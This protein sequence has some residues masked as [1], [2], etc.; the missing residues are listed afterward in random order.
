M[1]NILIAHEDINIIAKIK[2]AIK[3]LD[4]LNAIYFSSSDEA[5]EYIEESFIDIAV[6]SLTMPIMN[7]DEIA[8][9]IYSI[10]P[11]A[12]FCFIYDENTFD[13]GIES[14]NKYLGSRIIDKSHFTPDSLSGA[15]SFLYE[16]YVAEDIYNEQLDSYRAKEKTYKTTMNEMS[17]MLNSR[18]SCYSRVTKVYSKSI[19]ELCLSFDETTRLKIENF[20]NCVFGQY[21]QDVL[22]E[23]VDINK[24]ILGLIES[25]NDKESQRHYQFIYDCPLP[26][27]D[28]AEN[29]VFSAHFLSHLF[30][31]FLEKFRMKLELK[32]GPKVYRLD[33]LV[34][35]RLGN[36]SD[37]ILSIL[38]NAASSSLKSICYKLEQVS[39]SGIVQIRIYYL[40]NLKIVQE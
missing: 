25:L 28:T 24:S 35:T 19:E 32:D 12:K 9:V 39:K 8:D 2:T 29:I 31:E 20:F 30:A 11:N 14:F 22:V 36:A 17:A 3:T 1:I 21:I 4:D 6:L 26:E 34:D 37:E 16:E 18:I 7:G 27:G 15:I 5:F 33:V 13:L 23:S 40:K 10:N 38:C